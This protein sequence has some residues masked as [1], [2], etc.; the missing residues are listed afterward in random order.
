MHKLTIAALLCAGLVPALNAQDI[1]IKPVGEGKVEVAPAA[2]PAVREIETPRA[3]VRSSDGMDQ[4]RRA[5]EEQARAEAM[6][7]ADG[8]LKPEEQQK[9]VQKARER[10][11]QDMARLEQRERSNAAEPDP[12]DKAEEAHDIK[13]DR[14]RA[15]LRALERDLSYRVARLRKP[16]GDKYEANLD[17]LID[18]VRDTF[19]D[20]QDKLD[21]GASGTWAG[22][23]DVARKFYAD[24][25][26]QAEKWG[27]EIGIDVETP[28]ADQ[29][30]KQMCDDLVARAKRL[31]SLGGGKYEDQ[32]ESVIDRVSDTFETLRDK[33]EDLPP[34]GWAEVLATGEKAAAQFAAELDKWAKAI[35]ADENLPAPGERLNT[36]SRDLLERIA[37]LR[38]QAGDKFED[39]LDNLEDKVRDTFADL[40]ERALNTTREH[41]PRI[42]EDAAKFHKDYSEQI[43]AWRVRVEGAARSANPDAQ[44][45][46]MPGTV[47]SPEKDMKLPGGVHA[48]IVDG[49]RIARVQ[50]IV[51]KQLGLENGL[52]VKEITDADGALA[53]LGIE[54]YDIILE[55]KG[56]AVDTRNG[57]REVMDGVKAGEEY[58]LVILRDGKKQTLTGKK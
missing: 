33:L 23:L 56:A 37:T 49:V 38:R 26:A 30:L 32:L 44:P 45:V 13:K 57:L 41:W 9:L 29:R 42:L 39:N 21:D 12:K 55:A 27:K 28:N 36:L 3:E 51:R 5:I 14:Y 4:A 54:V 58:S 16:G 18:K 6:L 17:N 40:K 22:T 52:E 20:L 7:L 19:A 11:E 8:D 31:H 48:D 24:F 1:K 2:K 15:S 46:P 34:K 25:L 10:L 53:R 50:P 35:G 43:E 47:K